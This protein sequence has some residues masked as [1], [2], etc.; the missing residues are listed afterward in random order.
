[1]A[2]AHQACTRALRADS[3]GNGRSNTLDGTP[4]NI[5]DRLDPPVR[6]N[7]IDVRLFEGAWTKDGAVC[8]SHLRWKFLRPECEVPHC[9]SPA[10]AQAFESPTGVFS[11]S[12]SQTRADA[13]PARI[14]VFIQSS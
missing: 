9:D 12:L 13:P 4:I 14:A 5:L 6:P 2:D 7:Y 11:E 8:L 3:C 1:M 10:E